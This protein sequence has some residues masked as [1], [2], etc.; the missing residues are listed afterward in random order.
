MHRLE[1][2]GICVSAAAKVQSRSIAGKLAHL[3][4]SADV[5]ERCRALAQQ[6][7]FDANL[8]ATCDAIVATADRVVGNRTD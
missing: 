8:Q 4:D 2:L 7:D 5:R 1:R 3:L 6:V